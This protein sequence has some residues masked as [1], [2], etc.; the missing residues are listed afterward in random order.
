VS[1]SMFNKIVSERWRGTLIYA[2]GILGYLLMIVAVYP[3]FKKI[4]TAKS[5]LL[6]NYPKQLLQFFGVKS[7]DASSFNNY[8]TIELLGLIWIVI[9]AAF[10]IAWTRAMISGEIHD[11]TMEL[12][13]AQPVARWQVLTSE[14]LGLL[15][16]IVALSVVTVVGSMAF[17]AA[18]GAK[19]SFTGF[20]V[21]LPLGICLSL[22]IGGYSLLLSALLDDPRRAVMA[23]AGLTLLFYLIHFGGTYS[24]VIDKIDWFGIFHYYNPLSVLDRGVVPV[25]SVLLL[26]AFAAVGFG[27]SLW[28][29]QRKDVK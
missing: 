29:F 25:K 14:G 17:G 1:R 27:A 15:V 19:I 11:G 10:V 23:S 2:L 12:L 28:V 4:L 5:E 9:M 22:A 3:T 8:I 21:F 16:G 24:K 7:L 18:F 6:K 26:L 13:L 20:A